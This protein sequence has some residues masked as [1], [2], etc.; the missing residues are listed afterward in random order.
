M[1]SSYE[2]KSQPPSSICTGAPVE[3]I[4]P[5]GDAGF[6]LR[7]I[8]ESLVLREKVKWYSSMLGK[9]GSVHVVVARLKEVGV[10]NWAVALLRAGRKTRRWTVA[11]SF[12][13]WRPRN[14]RLS[15]TNCRLDS[16][17]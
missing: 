11:W 15:S 1:E 12:G 7:M 6:V 9:L 16:K 3:M 17:C 4:T 10:G 14:V 5:G 8:D 2:S 13:D